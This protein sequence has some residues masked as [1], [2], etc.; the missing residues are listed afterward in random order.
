MLRRA[1]AALATP[2]ELA[3]RRVVAL[4]LPALLCEL[5]EP[6]LLSQQKRNWPLGVV[7]ADGPSVSD[8]RSS[9]PGENEPEA[10]SEEI[11]ATSVLSAVSESA[12][13][14]GV[15]VGQTL[16]EA[17]AL[18]SRLVVRRVSRARVDQAL[19][20]VAEIAMAFG[21]TVSFAAPDTV[22]VDV[23]GAAHLFGGEAGLLLELLGRVREAG[24]R[25][26]AALASGPCLAQAFARHG[27]VGKAGYVLVPSSQ[28]ELSLSSLPVR[29]LE[30]PM[31][32]ERW[33]IRLGVLTLAELREL[34]R[35][36]LSARLGE[37]AVRVLSFIAGR[38][39][40]PLVAYTP[41]RVLCEESSWDD[42]SAGSEP[43]LF[44]LRGLASRLG[45][46]LSG[47]GEAARAL[48]LEIVAD[49]ALARFRG[50]ARSTRL[51]FALPK[52]LW[53][54]EEI[55][56]IVASKLERVEL[57]APSVGLRLEVTELTEAQP[58]QLE[59]G[60]WGNDASQ[61]LD[62]LPI[63][64]AELAADIGEERVGV[65]RLVDS[66]RPELSS[67][68]GPALRATGRSASS[69]KRTRR[70]QSLRVVAPE[71]GFELAHRLNRLLPEPIAIEAPLRLGATLALGRRLYTIESLR[72]E[73]RLEAVEW[74]T[75]AVNR[76]Y[77]R[78]GLRGAEGVLEG[79]V[80]VDR[81]SGK[82]YW[83]GVAD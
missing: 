30:L 21:A 9:E 37:H 3:E 24:H 78:V 69:K 62:E 36:A 47:R 61:A 10:K 67:E 58:R 57:G 81:E 60:L 14:L 52:P 32:L 82:R 79:L 70:V 76:D 15:R 77:V 73:Q 4:V 29:A 28:S 46:R 63:V 75:G 74:W 7:L 65:L 25:V 2:A 38:D 33:L 51:D 68:L 40:A 80:Y 35:S 45:A 64:L 50:V 17:R 71:G 34:P 31:E 6:R 72:F 48:R 42:P 41:P 56:R 20:R 8:E 59:L 44:V 54:A 23:S 49:S 12:L 39:S 22:W 55:N 26:R 13:R 53:K 11:V 1:E 83:Q 66:H 5:A 19:G 27:D 16:T 43:L 18:A